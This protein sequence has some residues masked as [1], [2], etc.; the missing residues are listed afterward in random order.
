[1]DGYERIMQECLGS[2][3]IPVEADEDKLAELMLLVAEELA[4]DRFGGATKLNKVLYFAEFSHVRQ[5]GRP[6][7]GTPYRKLPNGPAPRR[8]KPV[9][10][11]L[12]ARGDAALIAESVLGYRQDRLRPLRVADRSIF[13]ESE[14][15]VIADAVALLHGRT[16]AEVS[17][18]SHQEP[19]WKMVGDGEDIPYATAYLPALQP[20]PSP[21]TRARMR[22]IGEQYT[23]EGRLVS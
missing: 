5:T 21:A 14:R 6:I 16:A 9:R 10:E 18:L 22:E 12:I 8:L 1:M 19:G 13:T 3:D 23:R 20:E 4:D 7:T 17:D 11:R 2:Y 15:Q